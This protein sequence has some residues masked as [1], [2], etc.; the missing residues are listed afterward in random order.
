[1]ILN[2]LL[3]SILLRIKLQLS[4]VR[5]YMRMPDIGHKITSIEGQKTEIIDI[6]DANPKMSDKNI[7]APSIYL[8]QNSAINFTMST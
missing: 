7:S 5:C 6:L 4:K 1:M 3:D 8:Y 2:K